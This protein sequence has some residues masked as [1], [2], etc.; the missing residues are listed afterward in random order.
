MAC[1]EAAKA[2]LP[3]PLRCGQGPDYFFAEAAESGAPALSFDFLS[4]DF[5]SF[6]FLSDSVPDFFDLSV[7]FVCLDFDAAVVGF[8]AAAG[9]DWA[10]EATMAVDNSAATSSD[11]FNLVPMRSA[12]EDPRQLR[13]SLKRARQSQACPVNAAIARSVDRSFDMLLARLARQAV[14]RRARGR[15]QALR[16]RRT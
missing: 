2:G 8:S 7:D 16:A 15:S 9:V 5:L 6:D 10:Y 1:P 14:T 12:V 3:Q 11:F 13:P 4:S